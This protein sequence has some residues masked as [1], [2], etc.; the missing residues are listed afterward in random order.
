MALCISAILAS[1]P[2][3]NPELEKIMDPLISNQMTRFS[4]PSM[5]I[6]GNHLDI[7]DVT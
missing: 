7:Y 4:I 1:D 2:V 3:K 5:S 6:A